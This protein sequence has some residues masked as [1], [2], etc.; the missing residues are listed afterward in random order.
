MF[1]ITTDLEARAATVAGDASIQGKADAASKNN[2]TNMISA[3]RKARCRS[4]RIYMHFVL[5]IQIRPRQE[6]L[7]L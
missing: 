7:T 2:E 1:G 4:T 5:C 3:L 6:S